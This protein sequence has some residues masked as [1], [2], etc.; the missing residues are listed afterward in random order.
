MSPLLVPFFLP[1]NF[2]LFQRKTSMLIAFQKLRSGKGDREQECG[3]IFSRICAA[4]VESILPPSRQH[5]IGQE[6]PTLEATD[7][8]FYLACLL[9]HLEFVQAQL[10]TTLPKQDQLDCSPPGAEEMLPLGL[11]RALL[12]FI[13]YVS[14]AIGLDHP[15][16]PKESFSLVL[17]RHSQF[18]ALLFLKWTK[19]IVSVSALARDELKISLNSALYSGGAFVEESLSSAI[20]FGILLQ[21]LYSLVFQ[22]IFIHLTLLQKFLILH[23]QSIVLSIN[24]IEYRDPSLLHSFSSPNTRFFMAPENVCPSSAA[25]EAF[26]AAPL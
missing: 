16:E 18:L 9:K 22:R 17:V 12:L 26:A 19:E 5:E 7:K 15:C 3:P 10:S 24:F 25:Q 8:R 4:S 1:P 13:F 14:V 6:R 20:V 2:S 23:F 11:V 21:C